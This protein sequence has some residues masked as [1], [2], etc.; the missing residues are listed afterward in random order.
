M[1]LF[2]CVLLSLNTFW[3]AALQATPEWKSIEPLLASKCYECH[4]ETKTKGDVDLKRLAADPQ[5]TKEHELWAKVLHTVESGEMPPKKVKPYT[6][7]EKQTV[8]RWVQ[9]ALEQL[10][11]AKSGDPGLVTMRRLT[12]AEYDYTIRD[13]T[14]QELH[15]AAEFQTDGGGGEGFSNTGDVLFLSPGALDKYLVAARKLADHATIMPGTGIVFHPQRIGIRG[16]QQILDQAQQALY[17]WYQQKAAPHLPKDLEDMHEDE[18]MLACWKHKHFKT[19]LPE[20]A[21]QTNLSP[22]FLENWWRLLNSTK[23]PSRYM[24]LTRARWRG[25]PAVDPAQPHA[26]PANVSQGIKT[27]TQDLL[28]WNDPQNPGHGVQRHQQDADG[29]R[30]YT[31]QAQDLPAQARVF[32]N[33]GTAGDGNR[34]DI[35]IITPGQVQLAGKKKSYFEWIIQQHKEDSRMLALQ[36]PQANVERIRQRHQLLGQLMQKRGKHPKGRPIDPTAIVLQA[37]AVLELPVPDKAKAISVRAK[38]DM[39]D[40]GVKNASVQTA[41]SVGK[42]RDT[43]R[44]MSGVLTVYSTKGTA[45]HRIYGDFAV[46]KRALPDSYERRLEVVADNFRAG[47]SPISVYYFS[48]EQ[49]GRLLGPAD[50][51]HLQYMKEDWAYVSSKAQDPTLL[52]QAQGKIFNHLLYYARRAWRRPLGDTEKQ[53]LESLFKDGLSKG[54]GLESAAREVLVS[55][56]VSPH[57]LFKAETLPAQQSPAEEL[58]LNAHELA[59]RLSYFIWASMPDT[60]LRRVAD[61]ASLLKPQVM[62]AQIQR[63]LKHPRATALAREFAAQWLKFKDFS[64]TQTVDEKKFPEFTPELRADM[65][66]EVE[67]FFA[68]LVANDR[69]VMDLI[70]GENTFVNERLAQFYGIPDVKGSQFIPVSA[71]AQQRGGVL[72][73]AA[74]LTKTSR[75]SRTSP[76]LRGDYLYH[77]ILGFHSPPP[78]PNV[79]ELKNAER[80]ASLRE[81]LTQHRADQAC[82]VCH[83]RIDPLGFTL[84]SFDPIGRY[85]ASDETGAKI[86]DLGILKNGTSLQGWKGLR[87]YLQNN[88]DPF[89]ENFCRKLLGYSLGRQV[90]PT[91]KALLKQMVAALKANGM[92]FST[93]VNTIAQSRQFLHRRNEVQVAAGQ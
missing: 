56:M 80:P 46:L 73:M 55:L 21:K 53:Q 43:Q 77:V 85:R 48:D 4:N 79:P 66:Q 83:D 19:P 42:P 52:T 81:A 92:K 50:K 37:P 32:L 70:T 71:A 93:A 16:E 15:L 58:P 54:L 82:S 31:I 1:R 65:Q 51:Q 14:K 12:N 28:S 26:V 86:D 9:Q 76:V 78:P 22:F 84:E 74:I 2:L 18:Y 72:G 27:I 7:T 75:S 63:M 41:L 89:L 87:Q 20:L 67:A 5:V 36:P 59:S 34:G 3:K 88:Q 38:L 91:D 90:L 33:V 6:T 49:L 11:A 24:D 13:L 69:S 61:D 8:L 57:F 62:Q 60:E 40:E 35:V 17:I 23:P 25:L 39:Q 10:A 44:I 68:D 47:T 45:K 29:I 30:N 64:L